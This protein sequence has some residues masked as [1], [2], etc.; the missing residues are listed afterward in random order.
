MTP[1]KTI[2]LTTSFLLIGVAIGGYLFA[3]SQPRPLF[4]LKQCDECLSKSEM[5][6]LLASVGINRLTPFL[7][8]VVW[9]TDKTIVFKYPVT[10]GNFHY[11]FMPKKDIKN[12]GEFSEEDAGY[13]TDA[14]L[15]I[16]YIIQRDGLFNYRVYTNGPGYQDV[17]YLHFHLAG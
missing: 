10:K 13:I 16:R 11:L 14:F 2:L 4:S 7:P 15:A 6:G 9:Q 1:F 17:S 5:Y 3:Q 8:F 12:I